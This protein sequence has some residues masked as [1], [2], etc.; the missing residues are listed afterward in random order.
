MTQRV[1]SEHPYCRNPLFLS[2][3][4][5]TF[6]VGVQFLQFEGS[7]I[8]FEYALV[9]YQCLETNQLSHC[10]LKSRAGTQSA[11]NLF[12]GK[13]DIYNE[14]K[15]VFSIIPRVR[16]DMGGEIPWLLHCSCGPAAAANAGLVSLERALLVHIIILQYL[17]TP[18]AQFQS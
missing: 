15:E 16:R 14:N 13:F 1:R 4:T 6:R 10:P 8:I 5:R 9:S 3:A 12:G 17:G 2:L 11:P 18:Q 7:L